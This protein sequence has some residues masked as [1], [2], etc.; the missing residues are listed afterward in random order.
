M[1]RSAFFSALAGATAG[2][3]VLDQASKFLAD[4]LLYGRG[5]VPVFGDFFIL[6]YARNRGAF[7]SLG[8]KTSEAI[9]PV[10]FIV[11]PIVIIAAFVVFM[12]RKGDFS[13]YSLTLA[14][15][16][17]SGGLGNIIDRIAYGSVRDFMNMGIGSL[18]TG[19]FNVADLYLMAF[20]A[21]VLL[22]EIR[23]VGKRGKAA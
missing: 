13:A 4:R 23:N 9:W 7:L 6:L 22:H 1:K 5:T 10:V 17:V 2:L 12:W 20:A 3:T 14:S 21:V 19:I 8:N 11:M 15:L 16:V 18:R